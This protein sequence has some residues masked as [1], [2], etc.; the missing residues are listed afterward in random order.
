VYKLVRIG[1]SPRLKVTSDL[2]KATLPGWKRLVRAVTPDGSFIQDIILLADDVVRPGDIVFDPANP[3]RQVALPH[4]A[5]LEEVRSVVMAN[6]KRTSAPPPTLDELADR[7]ADQ[8]QKLPEG[9]LRFINPHR[10]KV[11]I[12]DRLNELRLRLMKEA[13]HEK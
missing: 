8:L 2:A 5:R 10:Y 6:G 11:S 1:D 12:S 3:L 13:L 7:C 9:C 4:Y